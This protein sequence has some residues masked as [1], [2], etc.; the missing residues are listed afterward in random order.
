M[1]T[2]RT[3]L[4]NIIQNLDARFFTSQFYIKGVGG[5]FK[6]R[7]HNGIEKHKILDNGKIGKV[8]L[9]VYIHIKIK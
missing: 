2:L 1:N 7:L 3:M 9:F 6:I 8:N 5:P 4:T